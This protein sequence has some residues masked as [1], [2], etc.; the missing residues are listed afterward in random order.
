MEPRL[1][2]AYTVDV[3]FKTPAFLPSAVAFAAQR[4]D[5][6]WQLGVRNARSGKP[7]LTATIT[8]A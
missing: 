6:G 8:A 1:A 3:A 2:A 7:H 4:T 5:D